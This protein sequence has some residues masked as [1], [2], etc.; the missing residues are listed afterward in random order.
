MLT[1]DENEVLTRVGPGTAMGA[2]MRQYWIPVVRSDELDAGGKVKRVRL[3]GEPLIVF[4]SP[5]GEVGLLAEFCAH[6][7][8]SLFFG[9]NE[10]AGLRCVYH[11]WQ[12][13]QD[14]QCVDMPNEPMGSRFA[15]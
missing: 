4:R 10:R 13:A 14:G 11:G 5:D 6:R 8:A 2:L 15:E 3:L 9:R 1:R 12:Y 7:G